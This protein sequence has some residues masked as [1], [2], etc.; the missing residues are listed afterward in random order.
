MDFL[1]LLS[2]LYKTLFLGGIFLLLTS[3]KHAYLALFII[4]ISFILFFYWL[5]EETKDYIYVRKE[6]CGEYVYLSN[7]SSMRGAGKT[8]DLAIKVDGYGD[9]ITVWGKKEL[10]AKVNEDKLNGKTLC[11]NV[12][13]PVV[14]GVENLKGATEAQ[15]LTIKSKD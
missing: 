3:K 13:I 8:V 7:R 6:I 9:F 5:K 1:T 15:N 11:V 4:L 14:D 10:L 12:K 2:Y